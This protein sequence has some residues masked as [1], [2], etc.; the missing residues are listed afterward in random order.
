MNP[1]SGIYA[2]VR[3]ANGDRYVGSAVDLRVRFRDH[4]R[5]LKDNKH[6]NIHLQRAWN[7]YGEKAFE[8]RVLLYC[9]PELLIMFEQLAISQKS[10]YNISLTAGSSLGIKRT[11]EQNAAHSARTKK[12]ME[13]PKMRAKVAA[14][15]IGRKH[16]EEHKAKNAAA[17]MGNQRAKGFKHT[18]ET[19]AKVSAA[20][21]G[22]QRAKGYKY[23][24]EARTKM[25]ADRKGK[26]KTPE[27]IS[28][29]TASLRKF[30]ARK[31]VEREAEW[32]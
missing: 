8:F 10:E 5:D 2:I 4:R 22:N 7:K 21:M 14:G 13:D 23:T 1:R 32:E 12:Q 17:Q 11:P 6:H 15:Q 16:T 25:S 3:K 9:D 18:N 29:I 19:K 20:G 31:R 30:H 24:K 28:K 26:K 27:H